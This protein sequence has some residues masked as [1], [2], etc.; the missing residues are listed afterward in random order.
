MRGTLTA[1]AHG[2]DGARLLIVT[3]EPDST[4]RAD[5]LHPGEE[6]FVR[7]DREPCQDP[8]YFPKIETRGKTHG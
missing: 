7:T 8:L 2:T 3:L 4:D 1:I 6:V 5:D